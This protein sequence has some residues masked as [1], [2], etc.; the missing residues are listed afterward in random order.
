MKKRLTDMFSI[1]LFALLITIAL[2]DKSGRIKASIANRVIIII[3]AVSQL[4]F[5]VNYM[6]K[7]KRNEAMIFMFFAFF[8]VAIYALIYR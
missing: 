6:Q 4:N 8:L 7:N 1:L 2:L 3:L 5:G